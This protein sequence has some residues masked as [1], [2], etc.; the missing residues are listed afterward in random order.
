MLDSYCS[1]YNNYYYIII[2]IIKHN[3]LHNHVIIT[4]E[5]GLKNFY[6]MD[7]NAYFGDLK[8]ARRHET[9]IISLFRYFRTF[10]DFY[11]KIS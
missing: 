10:A 11:F 3:L 5:R 7:C 8:E 4:E 6:M 2:F 1:I 9:I